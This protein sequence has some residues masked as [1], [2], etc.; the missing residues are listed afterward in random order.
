P[1][2]V[3][4]GRA[5]GDVAARLADA[6]AKYVVGNHGIEAGLSEISRFERAI[7][8]VKPLLEQ[9][10]APYP[11]LEIEDKRYSLAIHYRRARRRHNARAAIDAAVTALPRP[12]RVIPGKLVANV[13]PAGAR[14]KGDI[15][16]DLRARESAD[17]A[18]YVGDDVTDEDV[19]TLDQPGRLLAMRVGKTTMSAAR[20]YLR[21]QGEI[22]GLLARLVTLRKGRSNR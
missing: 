1:C 10:L 16:L 13:I 4:S 21:D 7:A 12:M 11:G 2:A 19:F 22:D 3:I 14:N 8:T 9:A 5:R 17:I 20:F 6:S 18:L 15:L